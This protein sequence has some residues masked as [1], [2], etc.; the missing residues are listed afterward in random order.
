MNID[1]YRN[2]QKLPDVKFHPGVPEQLMEAAALLIVAATWI[3]VFCMNHIT[4]GDK[5][6]DACVGGTIT[7]ITFALLALCAYSPVKLINFPFRPTPQNITEQYVLAVRFIRIINI[8]M[9]L[10]MMS[11]TL[12]V[13]HP[14]AEIIIWASI[15][16]MI[17]ETTIYII[18]AKLRS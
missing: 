12:L 16:L 14:W 1:T 5:F 7:T 15:A 3:Y 9:C 4:G 13:Y 11:C 17:V 10:C 6:V 2:K 18:I 8:T